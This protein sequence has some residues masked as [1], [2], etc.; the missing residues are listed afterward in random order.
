MTVINQSGSEYYIDNRLYKKLLK[1]K[2]KLKQKDRDFVYIVDGDEGAGKSVFS[3]QLCKT[4]DENFDLSKVCMTPE[5]FRNRIL[6]SNK[7]EAI[8]YDEAFTGLSSRTPLNEINNILVSLMMQMRQKNLFVVI[9]LPSFF[10]LDKYAALWRA[11]GLFHVYFKEGNRGR[12]VFFSKKKKKLL[13]ILGKKF[14]NYGKP[15]SNFYGRF[16]EQ[17]IVNE[18]EYRI[19]K[20]EALNISTKLKTKSEKYLL[21]RNHVLAIIRKEYDLTY[22]EI[23]D[24]LNKYDMQLDRTVIERGI[25]KTTIFK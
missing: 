24:L 15:K 23:E 6:S 22:Q 19:K 25:E 12:F 4:I 20:E 5:E 17:Y 7:Y 3:M 10:I 11:R 8:L 16:Y 13:Y 18:Q 2:A 21:Q 1:I 9:T 14:F